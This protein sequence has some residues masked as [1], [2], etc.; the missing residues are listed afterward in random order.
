[1]S[2]EISVKRYFR[3]ILRQ[4]KRVFLWK[5]E[6]HFLCDILWTLRVINAPTMSLTWTPPHPCG[7]PTTAPWPAHHSLSPVHHN[8]HN[9]PTTHHNHIF[10]QHPLPGL[11][12]SQ[13]L[14]V[15]AVM[16]LVSCSLLVLLVAASSLAQDYDLGKL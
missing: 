15:K 1:M 14:Y 11:C 13:S 7:D 2:E 6:R 5:E 10:T 9:S 3:I 12:V 16:S 8:T 4:K